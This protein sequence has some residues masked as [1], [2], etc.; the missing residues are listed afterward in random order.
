MPIGDLALGRQDQ[1]PRALP[2]LGRPVGNQFARQIE[3]ELGKIHDR[4]YTG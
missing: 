4:R 1:K 2:R 3:I